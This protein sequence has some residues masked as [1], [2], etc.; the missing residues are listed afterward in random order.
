M[1]KIS[2]LQKRELFTEYLTRKGHRKT[3]E[4]Y[5]ILDHVCAINGHFDVEM[6]YQRLEGANFHVSRATLYN[7]IELL[8]D[9][10]LLVRHQFGTQGVQYECAEKAAGH[11]HLVCSHCGRIQEYKD[12]ALKA[13]VLS[14]KFTKFTPEYFSMYIFGLCSKCKYALKRKEKKEY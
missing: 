9:A 3:P 14:K 12:L 6:L 2:A 11:F 13:S 4:R 1:D 5:A 7:T 10:R 8:V